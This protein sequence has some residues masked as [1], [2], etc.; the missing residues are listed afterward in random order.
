MISVFDKNNL[1][2]TSKKEPVICYYSEDG[3]CGPS[4]LFFVVFTDRSCYGYSTYYEKS[5]KELIRDI[6]EHVPELRQVVGFS[7][8]LNYKR[9]LCENLEMVFL[10]LGNHAL[11]REDLLKQM[12][13]YKGKYEYERFKQLI[14][15][16]VGGDIRE[17]W[18]LIKTSINKWLVMF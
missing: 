4:G 18:G 11:I 5:D 14:E 7:G 6:I 1:E 9:K 2:E 15:N 10:G 16:Y 17:I 3:A 12:K 13:E 8:N